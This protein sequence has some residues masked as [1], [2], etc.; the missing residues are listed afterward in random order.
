M[1]L[2]L[3]VRQAVKRGDIGMLRRLVDPLIV[4]FHGASQHNYG[5]EMLYYR[6]LLSDAS[7]PELQ[8]AVLSSGLVN[9]LGRAD[10]F[11]PI[12]LA[13][14]HLNCRCKLDLRNFKNSTHDIELVFKRTALC[15]T[16]IRGVCD[17]FEDVYGEAMSGAHTSATAIPDMFFLAWN[18][19][20]SNYTSPQS[21]SAAHH[22][23]KK[24]FRS[25][26]VVHAG[27]SVLE[28]K[29]AQFNADRVQQSSTLP[30]IPAALPV[31]EGVDGFDGFVDIES[32]A[33]LV[34]HGFDAVDT[35]GLDLT[36]GIETLDLSNE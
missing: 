9:W 14:E 33:G 11:K 19:Y 7:T 24:Q 16:W 34:H 21:R 15:N 4:F 12:D 20:R 30:G 35:I 5:R 10:T 8:R 6:W 1:E 13:L 32:F 26:N 2:F 31:D 17:R 25:H 23:H 28:D 18:L 3:T 29:V 27:M 36:V 22:N